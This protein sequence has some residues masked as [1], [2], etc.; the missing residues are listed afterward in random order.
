MPSTESCGQEYRVAVYGSLKAGRHNDHYLRTATLVARSKTA[1]EYTMIDVGPYPAIIP[2]GDTPIEVEVYAVDSDTLKALDEL[3]DHP[4][5]YLRSLIRIE[6]LDAY[7][8][9][10]T[11]QGMRGIPNGKQRII[12]TGCW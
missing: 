12:E 1:P 6:N 7:I 3:E 9:I 5:R 8:Y 4:D 10:L 2:A 11:K